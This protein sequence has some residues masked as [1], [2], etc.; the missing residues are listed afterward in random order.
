[1]WATIPLGKTVSLMLE[2]DR[3]SALFAG[4]GLIHSDGRMS[5][6][7]IFLVAI[8]CRIAVFVG[9]MLWPIANESGNLVSPLIL[10]DGVDFPFYFDQRFALFELWRAIATP[11]EVSDQIR[12][13]P[14][15]PLL[16]R[17]FGYDAGHTIQLALI[18]LMMSIALVGVSLLWL[19]QRGLNWRWLLLFAVLPNPL[20][21]MVSI[22]T[23]L[24][25]SLLLACTVF[26]YI[27]RNLGSRH[28]LLALAFAAL[29]ALVR[30]NGILLLAFIAVDQLFVVRTPVAA[31]MS[32][33]AAAL[34]LV[35]ASYYVPYFLSF[36]TSSERIAYFQLSQDAY[37][38]GI[39]GFLPEMI[40]KA[41]SLLTL[42]GAKLL[43]F[44]GLRPSYG[45]TPVL[46]VLLRGA[47][48]LIVLPGLLLT[49][50]RR[51]PSLVLLTV[52]MLLPY[53]A[54]AAQDR[55]YLPMLPVFF[56]SGALFYSRFLPRL[57]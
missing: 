34:C 43:Y 4:I 10:Q 53:F 15:L 26:V 21:F 6:R 8:G 50:V 37:L 33:V 23:D 30:P 54:G 20:W 28:V 56:W 52:I 24:P 46:M 36:S 1:M 35:L 31:V 47:A 29:A 2:S 27:R 18:Y 41:L 38:G 48:G 42:I 51:E 25:F 32:G 13:G 45:E 22:S 11:F 39:Y 49:L 17:L 16:F 3:S 57:W 19:A 9:L 55:Y 7:G 12:P 40:D 44:A 5:F 14:A